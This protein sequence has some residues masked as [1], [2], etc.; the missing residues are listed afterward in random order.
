[1][2]LRGTTDNAMCTHVGR[3]ALGL[4]RP[5][6]GSGFA[7]GQPDR[8]ATGEFRRVR[9]SRLQDCSFMVRC[10]APPFLLH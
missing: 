3:V 4:L 9:R 2:F 7:L 8:F 6:R 10:D 5:L 1:M